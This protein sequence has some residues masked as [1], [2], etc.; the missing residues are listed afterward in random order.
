MKFVTVASET[1]PGLEIL[2]RSCEHFNIPLEVLGMGS[3]YRGNGTKMIVL[4]NYLETLQT[5]ELVLFTDAYDS[6]FVKPIDDI[7]TKLEASNGQVLF[8]CE[9]NYYYRL[10]G[11][12]HFFENPFY[13]K[14]Y[15]ESKS[16]YSPYRYLNS[17]GF[18][19]SAVDL[20]AVLRGAQIAGNMTSDQANL[21]K[22][23]V[24][25]PGKI[26][27]DYDHE[28]FTNYGKH[29]RP[30]RFSIEGGQ[31]MNN[32]TG[33]KPYLFHFPGAKHKGLTEYARTY[34]FL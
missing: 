7:E 34:G 29:S 27:L 30:E 11:L 10:Q 21:H 31:L 22:Y 33:A 26:A 13:K 5:S 19:G 28:V 18:V 2:Q 3:R 24:D 14:K 16:K 20:I 9:D 8:S 23:L 17:G 6:F 32:L 12:R 1:K 25:Q 4:L 15:P